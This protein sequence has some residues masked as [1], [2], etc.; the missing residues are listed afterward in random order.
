MAN[1]VKVR[2]KR[3]FFMGDAYTTFPRRVNAAVRP[4]VYG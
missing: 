4:D 3:S 2:L 1:A